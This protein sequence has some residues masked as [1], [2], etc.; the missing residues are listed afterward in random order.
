MLAA[1]HAHLQVFKPV[2]NEERGVKVINRMEKV[3]GLIMITFLILKIK[4]SANSCTSCVSPKF[5]AANPGSC[6]SACPSTYY[7]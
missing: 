4:G 7:P 2:D 1:R 6:V 5:L 3:I